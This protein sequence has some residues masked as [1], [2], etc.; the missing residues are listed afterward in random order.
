MLTIITYV[1][2]VSSSPFEGQQTPCKYF[3]V[4]PAAS[5]IKTYSAAI[6]RLP[7]AF[8]YNALTGVILTGNFVKQ[9][10]FPGSVSLPQDVTLIRCSTND[11][12]RPPYSAPVN[13]LKSVGYGKE[14]GLPDGVQE[15]YD[16]YTQKNLILDHNTLKIIRDKRVPLPQKHVVTPTCLYVSRIRITGDNM[17]AHLCFQAPIIEEAFNS[18][19]SKAIG[20][21]LSLRGQNGCPGDDGTVGTDGVHSMDAT[22]FGVHGM[23]G[24]DGNYGNNGGWGT[25][26]QNGGDAFLILSGSADELVV[27]GRDEFRVPLGG[28]KSEQVF[29]FDCHGGHGGRGG[30]GGRGGDGGNGGHGGNGAPGEDGNF[31]GREGG[32]GGDGGDGGDGGIG[33]HGGDAGDG[34]NS[35]NGGKCLIKTVDPRLLMLVEVDCMPG[36][37]GAGVKG[38]GGGIGGY[39]GIGGRRGEG[40][41]GGRGT[42]TYYHCRHGRI[43]RNGNRGKSGGYGLD[44]KSGQRGQTGGILWVVYGPNGGAIKESST[45]FSAMVEGLSVVP[46]F[47][48]GIFEPNERIAVSNVIVR[49]TG[50]LDLPHGVSVFMPSSQTI[51]F[52][53]LKFDIP[54][55][56]LKAGEKYIIPFKFY[57]RLTDLAPPNQPGPQTFEAEFRPRIERLGRP[58]K[59]SCF[60][61]LVQYP[62]QLGDLLSPE[63]MD[64]GEEAVFSIEVKNNSN[65]QYGT[66]EDSGGRVVLQLHFDSRLIPLGKVAP[67]APY[68]MTYDH[69]LTDSTFIEILELP[70]NQSVIVS[71][72]VHMESH[73]ELFDQ[74]LYKPTFTYETSLWSTITKPLGLPRHTTLKRWLLMHFWSRVKS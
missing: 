65:L 56:V 3:F 61:F 28:T 48:G 39:R 42:Y 71:I 31:Y 6:L 58:F 21:T 20:C 74:C 63:M 8:Y 29:L 34:G 17:P 30:Y 35:G 2:A 15:V 24:E 18:A 23:N 37:P 57:G 54:K 16:P 66:C 10:I 11:N 27:K 32:E 53:V 64:Q 51:N 60:K 55:D 41:I 68:V 46:E 9:R 5:E 13:Y 72:K 33:G 52:E 22:D 62:I 1:L 14:M 7:T 4:D 36:E 59:R 45:R 43:G 73:A 38:G 25:N 69:S 49:N 44:S 40:G 12:F 50:G 19:Q 67:D 47:E 26:G 70:P